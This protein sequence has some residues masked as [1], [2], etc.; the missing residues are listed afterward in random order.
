MYYEGFVTGMHITQNSC[1]V[2][3]IIFIKHYQQNIPY[4]SKW[5]LT[6]TND[7]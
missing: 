7:P 3:K 6:D 4:V 2:C 1:D 5:K